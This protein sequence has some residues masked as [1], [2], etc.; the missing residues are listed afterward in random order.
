MDKSELSARIVSWANDELGYRQK[1]SLVGAQGD[2]KLAD[3]DIEEALQGKMYTLLDMVSTHFKSTKNVQDARRR[4]QRFSADALSGN[5]IHKIDSELLELVKSHKKNVETKAWLDGEIEETK[6]ACQISINRIEALESKISK[7]KE[8]QRK[9]R[10]RIELKKMYI[11]DKEYGIHRLQTLLNNLKS[12]NCFI[13]ERDEQENCIRDLNDILQKCIL[14]HIQHHRASENTNSQIENTKTKLDAAIDLITSNLLEKTPDIEPKLLRDTI[15]QHII[16]TETPGVKD[17]LAA[18]LQ[19]IANT[20]TAENGLSLLNIE[21]DCD[22]VPNQ[23]SQL[24]NYIHEIREDGI[25]ISQQRNKVEEIVSKGLLANGPEL[26]ELLRK[27]CST[28]QNEC[29]MLA[30]VDLSQLRRIKINNNGDY[31]AHDQLLT[32]HR[33]IDDHTGKLCLL[34]MKYT[35]SSSDTLIAK[36]RDTVTK[37]AQQTLLLELVNIRKQ[38]FNEKL[39]RSLNKQEPVD[40]DNKQTDGKDVYLLSD[41]KIENLLSATKK[42][43]DG[44]ISDAHHKAKGHIEASKGSGK[45]SQEISEISSGREMVFSN[46]SSGG[47]LMLWS[48][49]SGDP[50]LDYTSL[51]EGWESAGMSAM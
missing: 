8:K 49:A 12:F 2:E 43:F 19:D 3:S 31:K 39:M 17:K 13:E 44:P 21:G 25:N 14:S 42:L 7:F 23:L 26:I 38:E 32:N 6:E 48:L 15:L 41:K 51:A 29:A 1:L 47:G 33:R 35:G 5:N 37:D 30:K 22:S 16:A 34:L 36:V 46:S 4:I 20:S 50:K 10:M 45:Y 18:S 27:E 24:I 28:I 11:E 40:S 9:Q